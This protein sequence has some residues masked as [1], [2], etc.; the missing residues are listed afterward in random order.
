MH[1][2]WMCDEGHYP[3]EASSSQLDAIVYVQK[4]SCGLWATGLKNLT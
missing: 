3:A 2:H 1:L 4:G